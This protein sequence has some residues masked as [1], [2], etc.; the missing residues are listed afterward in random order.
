[1]SEVGVH[2]KDTEEC[3]ES[4][5]QVNAPPQRRRA[6]KRVGVGSDTIRGVSAS[7]DELLGSENGGGG[8]AQHWGAE[9]CSEC[10]QRATLGP[11]CGAA[12]FKFFDIAAVGSK[13][14]G[15]ARTINLC[16][17]CYNESQLKQGEEEVHGVKRRSMIEH[18]SF[19]GKLWAAFG[20][21]QFLRGMRERFTI[22]KSVRQIGLSRCRKCGAIRTDGRWQH[23]TP[24][25]EEFELLRHSIDLRFGALLMCQAHNAGK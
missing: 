25:K 18:K 10:S 22:K 5:G 20:V 9:L 1:M 19:R 4:F 15:A 8:R 17:S 13:Q 12:G 14:G 7:A 16:R 21:D 6:V 3:E 23:E 2:E 24:Y 11:A